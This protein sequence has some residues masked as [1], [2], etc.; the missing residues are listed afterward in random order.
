LLFFFVGR[1]RSTFRKK[2]ALR[3]ALFFVLQGTF[4]CITNVKGL[5]CYVKFAHLLY[6]KPNLFLAVCIVHMRGGKA[7][8]RAPATWLQNR[9]YRNSALGGGGGVRPM[10]RGLLRIGVVHLGKGEGLKRN[11]PKKG[12]CRTVPKIRIMYSQK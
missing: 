1:Y 2:I 3:K 10:E 12:F 6:C 7:V 5:F 11:R 4:L 9:Q 8:S